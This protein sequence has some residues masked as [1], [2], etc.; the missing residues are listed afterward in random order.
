MV[1]CEALKILNGD[2]SDM[3]QRLQELL[4]QYRQEKKEGGDA[5]RE[6]PSSDFTKTGDYK[7]GQQHSEKNR[8]L[9]V[10]R[11]PMIT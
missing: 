10:P 1:D 8:S 11:A 9:P 5:S 3:E 7:Q 6:E 4:E 2:G